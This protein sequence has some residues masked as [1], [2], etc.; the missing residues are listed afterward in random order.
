MKTPFYPQTST[1]LLQP[2]SLKPQC[3]GGMGT[4]L[5]LETGTVGTVFPGTEAAGTAFQEPKPELYPSRNNCCSQACEPHQNSSIHMSYLG[6]F[7]GV[8]RCHKHRRIRESCHIWP[9]A[10][11]FMAASIFCVR[12][13]GGPKHAWKRGGS[14]HVNAYGVTPPKPSPSQA[15]WNT[16]AQIFMSYFRFYMDQA[17]NA[18]TP[19]DSKL[20]QNVIPW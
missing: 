8:E 16:H 3:Q 10:K 11:Y 20:L 7:S 19:A 18:T 9:Q 17:M 14:P 4:E 13:V 15:A 6:L 1:D 2:P 5:E 12:P